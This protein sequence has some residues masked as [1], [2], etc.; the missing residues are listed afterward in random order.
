MP[1]NSFENYPM[2]WKPCILK[3]GNVPL[4]IEI[5]E[6]LEHD[7]RDGILQPNEKLPPQ[8]ELADYLDVNLSTIAKAFK[9]CASK[10]LIFGETGRGTYVS[11]DVLSNLP[12]LDEPGLEHCINLGA[13]HPSYGQNL[14]IVNTLKQILKKTN[15]V[16]NIFEYSGLV[17]R[18]GHRKSGAK[19]MSLFGI[20]VDE[21]NIIITSGL[22]NGLAVTLVSL[23]EFGD[24]IATNPV[25][26]SGFKNIANS[27]GIQLIP[28]PYN[29]YKM[30]LKSLRQV[31]SHDRIKGIYLM[32]DH[33]NPTAMYMENEE[34]Y[35]ISDIIKKYGLICIEDGTYSFLNE[36]SRLPIKALVPDQTVYICS[37]SNSLSPGFRIA[38][39]AAPPGYIK[40][41]NQANSNI[42]VMA[43]PLEEELVSQLINNGLAQKMVEEKREEMLRRNSLVEQYLSRYNILGSNYSQFRWLI[44]PKKWSGSSFERVAKENGV[45]VFGNER[46]TVGKALV[47]P[48]VRLSISTPKNMDQLEKGISIISNILKSKRY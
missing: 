21:D 23:F 20:N 19:W 2:S 24:K 36:Y 44:L 7:I 31:C 1:V 26:Y 18:P 40:Q 41:M 29:G 32:P 45:Q 25:T 38:F 46:F 47:S 6:K 13:S 17:G 27:L 12:I 48:A 9:L 30:D 42:N 14:Y 34:R 15:I 35:E 37:V 16:S 3:N 28:I 4:H 22:Q 43:P 11:S 10:G 39:V 8:R 5:A 33:H